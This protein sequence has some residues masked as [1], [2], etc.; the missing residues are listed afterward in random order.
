MTFEPEKITKQHVL[1]GIKKIETEKIELEPS[2]KYDVL[3][4]GKS[5]PPKEVMRFAHEMMNGEHIWERTGGEPTNKYLTALG[6]E[7]TDKINEDE[8]STTEDGFITL[9]RSVGEVNSTAFF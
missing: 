2:T 3:I 6:F 1:E 7:V 5:Y 9:L 4:N 8:T